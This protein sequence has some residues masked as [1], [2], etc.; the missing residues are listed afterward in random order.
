MLEG[1]D[2]GFATDPFVWVR[3]AYDKTRRLLY[4]FDEIYKTGLSNRAAVDMIVKRGGGGGLIIADS[5]EPKSIA[6]F[7]ELGLRTKKAYKGP[8]SLAYGMKFL[9]LEVVGIVIDPRRCPNA[10]REFNNYEYERDENG[11]CGD[12]YPDRNNH[13]IDAVRYALEPYMNGDR[14]G[15]VKFVKGI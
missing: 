6:E 5:A 4:V 3:L 9:I 15:G 12:A 14:I 8:G 1:V 2:W 7:N 10:A 11:L 13:T